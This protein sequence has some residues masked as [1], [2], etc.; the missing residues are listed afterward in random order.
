MRWF[1]VLLFILI[2]PTA[3]AQTPEIVMTN[4]DVEIR[5]SG[6]ADWING[7]DVTQT[8]FSVDSISYS[9]EPLSTDIKHTTKLNEPETWEV[10]M[11]RV[12]TDPWQ[13]ISS[14]DSD[15]QIT[16]STTGATSGSAQTYQ[17]L[18]V[19]EAK[20]GIAN[21]NQVI[22][23][24]QLEVATLIPC[25]REIRSLAIVQYQRLYTLQN[26][27]IVLD[28][29]YYQGDKLD[30]TNKTKHASIYYCFH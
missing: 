4:A 18:I 10:E 7:G 24:A 22:N 15:T 9:A 2:T 16:L 14:V 11:F 6:E 13:T 8:I 20:Y 28:K 27:L 3:F 29:V 30:F 12:G 25:V 26:D 21:K 23:D 5:F 1:I 17:I 19:R